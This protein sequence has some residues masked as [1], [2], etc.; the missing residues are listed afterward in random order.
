MGGGFVRMNA[1]ELRDWVFA[2]RAGNHVTDT[3]A[4]KSVV[5]DRN[6]VGV[7]LRG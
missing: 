4:R 5:E 6:I 7:R 3:I 1:N 2:R